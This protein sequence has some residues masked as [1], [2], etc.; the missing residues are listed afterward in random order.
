MMERTSKM[1][2]HTKFMTDT[3]LTWLNQ[4]AQIKILKVQIGQIAIGNNY[5]QQGTLRRII[6]VNPKEQYSAITL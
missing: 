5:R 3:R 1:A 2:E 4:V 6:K